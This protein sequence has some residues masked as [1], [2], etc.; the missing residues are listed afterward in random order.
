MDAV[1]HTGDILERPDTG[2]GIVGDLVEILLSY[3]KPIVGIVGNH[4]SWGQNPK[5]MR[6]T[7]LNIVHKA[8]V[9]DFI[10]PGDK[11]FIE[12]DGIC[13]RITGQP[14]HYE[15]DRRDPMLDYYVDKHDCDIAVHMVHGMLVDKPFPWG[16]YTLLDRVQTEADIILCGHYHPGFEHV[17]HRKGTYFCNPGSIARTKVSDVDRRPRVALIEIDGSE[18]RFEFIPLKSA[19]EGSQVFNIDEVARAKE[20][21]ERTRGWTERIRDIDDYRVSDPLGIIDRVS[22][23]TRVTPKVVEQAKQRLSDTADKLGLSMEFLGTSTTVPRKIVRI[24]LYNFQAHTA[25]VFELHPGLNVFCGPTNSGKSSIVRALGW[26]FTNRWADIYMRSG[27]KETRVVVVYDDGYRVEKVRNRTGSVNR[28][29]V[30]DP[31][32]VSTEYDKFGTRIPPEVEAIMGMSPWILDDGIEINPKFRRQEDPIF[33]LYDTGSVKAKAIGYST[34]VHL[35]DAAIRDADLD[36]IRL[37]RDEKQLLAEHDQLV[38]QMKA[39][40]GIEEDGMRLRK[41][42]A[43]LRRL[44]EEQDLIARAEQQLAALRALQARRDELQRVL[45]KLREAGKAEM[46]VRSLIKAADRV[47]C[48]DRL[49]RELAK[50]KQLRGHLVRMIESM[51]GVGALRPVASQVKETAHFLANASEK[52][53]TLNAFKASRRTTLEKLG[54]LRPIA[55]YLESAR[56][57]YRDA[58]EL[59]RADKLAAALRVYRHREQL[60]SRWLGQLRVVIQREEYART[61]VSNLTQLAVA[62]DQVVCLRTNQEKARQLKADLERLRLVA[63]NEAAARHLKA[64]VVSLDR[65]SHAAAQLRRLRLG[66]ARLEYVLAQL[67]AA[68]TIKDRVEQLRNNVEHLRQADSVVERLN[69]LRAQLQHCNIQLQAARDELEREK[70]KYRDMLDAMTVCPLCNRPMSKGN[71]VGHQHKGRQSEEAVTLRHRS[72]TTAMEHETL[73][74]L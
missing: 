51:A 29:I 19:P 35:F 4:D 41:C 36:L 65:A 28:Y 16:P 11:R 37:G 27:A 2:S 63:E 25:S 53:A 38:E 30:T 70:Q 5:S 61:V 52:L 22:K 55:G 17:F 18:I 43:Q 15:I 73:F 45:E 59:E 40:D 14:F 20:R 13:L 33:L 12:K 8:K 49:T 42:L 3:E 68:A 1:L 50:A 48:A 58:Q 47:A 69:R 34:G 72:G 26:L 66:A 57:L 64:E 31:S 71:G 74:S 46:A 54:M 21:Q 62:D 9:I 56:N 24:E 44:R 10:G 7:V 32:G 6:S 23:E 67:R 39:Y 60:A